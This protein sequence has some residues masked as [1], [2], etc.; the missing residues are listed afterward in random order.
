MGDRDPQPQ[1][2]TINP[3]FFIHFWPIDD[4]LKRCAHVRTALETTA[5]REIP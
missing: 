5:I 1:C 4:A 3:L 2:W